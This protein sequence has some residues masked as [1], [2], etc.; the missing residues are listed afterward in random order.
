MGTSN[1]RKSAKRILPEVVQAKL[2]K[3]DRA[4]TRALGDQ[5]DRRYPEYTLATI[6]ADFPDQWVLILP[7]RVDANIQITAGRVF[8]VSEQRDQ[9]QE[10]VN[11]LRR[12][13]PE[14][15]FLVIFTGAAPF[16]GEFISA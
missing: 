1:R 16:G 11:A 7:T 13:H 5:F 6:N 12:A 9:F 15:G 2:D 8:A 14:T 4:L 3:A 10:Q